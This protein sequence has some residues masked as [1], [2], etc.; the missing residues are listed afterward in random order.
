[1]SEFLKF[2]N[3]LVESFPLHIE[4][5]Y[6]KTCDWSIYIYKKGCAKDYPKSKASGDDAVLCNVRSCDM[7]LAFAKAEVQVKEWLLEHNGGY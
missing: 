5:G 7:E 1:V 6:N 2:L 4:I 3:K